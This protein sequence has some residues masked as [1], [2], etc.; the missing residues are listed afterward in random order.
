MSDHNLFL[1]CDWGTTRLR[2]RVVERATG[3]I[4]YESA[5]E[6][7]VVRI[8]ARTQVAGRAQAFADVLGEHL[9]NLEAAAGRELN[10]LP[11]VISGMASSSLGWQELPYAALPFS[12]DGVATVS[13]ELPALE[14]WPA[15]RVFLLSGVCGPLDVMRGEETE[16]I[17][18]G[19]LAEVAPLLAD[20]IVMLPGTHSK[21]VRVVDGQV[22]AF[23]TF[24]TGELFDLLSRQSSLK[25]TPPPDAEPRNPNADAAFLAGVDHAQSQA[26]SA[27]LFAVR[28]RVLLQGEEPS[29][30]LAFLS[31]VLIG[32]ELATLRSDENANR[33]LI[34]CAGRSVAEGYRAACRELGLESRL[35]VV[36]P[37]DVERL[38]ALGQSQ[39]LERFS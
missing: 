27:A 9:K 15:S 32:A 33:P 14:R 29:A 35:R 31:G 24:M 3:A 13:R 34:L 12:L 39:V 8:A 36:A 38:S 22:V 19:R 28:A 25:Q 6:E 37:E 18:L 4:L 7:G 5:A 23:Q 2:V 10:G 21:H 11:I 30:A 1:S 17:G 20:A 26:L 16:L